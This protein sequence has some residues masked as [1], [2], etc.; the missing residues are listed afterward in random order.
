[1]RLNKFQRKQLDDLAVARMNKD[2]GEPGRVLKN[3]HQ[4]RQAEEERRIV[5]EVTRNLTEEPW[6]RSRRLNRESVANFIGDSIDALVA[7][8]FFFKAYSHAELSKM[9]STP[10]ARPRVLTMS[11]IEAC[12]AK[13]DSVGGRR[14]YTLIFDDIH[15]IDSDAFAAAEVPAVKYAV[16]VDF[17]DPC[18]DFTAIT[19]ASTC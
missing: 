18:T 12:A 19:L 1:M 11:D 5:A 16:G 17:A 4:L 6:E 15:S 14:P 8:H 3:A 9:Y 13:L 7:K 10:V 2:K